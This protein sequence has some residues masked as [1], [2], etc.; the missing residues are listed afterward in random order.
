MSAGR[1]L[2]GV[3]VYAGVTFPVAYVWHLVLFE[4]T[5]RELGYFTQEP[6][7]AIGFLAIV[8]QGG[9]LSFV[10]CRFAPGEAPLAEG[11]RFG[12]GAGFFLWTSQVLAF[13]AKHEVASIP[14]W[15]TIET[16][17]FAVQFGLVGLAYGLLLAPRRQASR[18]A[19]L[20]AF[21]SPPTLWQDLSAYRPAPLSLRRVHQYLSH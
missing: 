17:Y 8:L 20:R 9:W 15:L 21:G 5:Y 7:V 14:T 19:V 12:L 10:Y 4:G 13:T 16:V 1:F 11:L 2:A 18:A 6:I 3:L